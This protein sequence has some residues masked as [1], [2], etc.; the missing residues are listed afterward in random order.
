MR[1]PSTKEAVQ[2]INDYHYNELQQ[3]NDSNQKEQATVS[4][5]QYQSLPT[6]RCMNISTHFK[7]VASRDLSLDTGNPEKPIFESTELISTVR[8]FASASSS[9]DEGE[10]TSSAH[11][12]TKIMFVVRFW[13][14]CLRLQPEGL[15][16]EVCFAKNLVLC[17]SGEVRSCRQFS[18]RITLRISS[19]TFIWLYHPFRHATELVHSVIHL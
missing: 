1:G 12:T 5:I 16:D 15:V 11:S 3:I 2:K 4:C 14:L 10:K 7:L 6:T 9:A 18:V 17:K 19:S 13:N 8:Q